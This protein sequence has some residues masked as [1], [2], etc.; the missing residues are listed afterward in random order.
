MLVSSRQQLPFSSL[1]PKRALLCRYRQS[2]HKLQSLRKLVHS[3]WPRVGQWLPPA[4]AWF[5]PRLDQPGC[6]LVSGSSLYRTL[7]GFALKLRGLRS[8]IGDCPRGT[9]PAGS[10]RSTAVANP[11][12]LTAPWFLLQSS[13]SLLHISLS[14]SALSG[15]RLWSSVPVRLWSRSDLS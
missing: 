14:S 9:L 12:R 10:D 2:F 5:V 4:V 8:S 3:S 1:L 13:N 11:S 15:V 6:Y 7:L